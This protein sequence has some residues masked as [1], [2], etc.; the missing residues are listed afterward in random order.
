MVEFDNGS[1]SFVFVELFDYHFPWNGLRSRVGIFGVAMDAE[2]VAFE[3]E[4]VVRFFRRHSNH[5]Y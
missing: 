4:V 1:T 5:P 3:N 2:D